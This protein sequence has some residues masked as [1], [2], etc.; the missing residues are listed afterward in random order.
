MTDYQFKT[1]GPVSVD[2]RIA[3]G[4]IEI[5][6][7]ADGEVAVELGGGG[8]SD[9]SVAQQGSTIS[10]VSNR[11]NVFI[12]R[13]VYATIT[14][15]SGSEVR[16]KVASAD[17]YCD[18][19]VSHIS[20]NSASGD[21]RFGETVEVD[22]KTASGDLRG[23]SVHERLSFVSASGDLHLGDIHGRAD[24]STASGDMHVDTVAAETNVSTMSGDIHIN[25]F[26][27]QQLSAKSMS[28]NVRLGIPEGTR[29]DL[30]ANS[31]SGKIKLPDRKPANP[32]QTPARTSRIAVKLVSGD[33]TIRR[34]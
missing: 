13:N 2:I 34:A 27:G 18:T 4:K 26:T 1:D 24:V 25:E 5:K 32:S 9:V 22:A 20:F 30:D 33:L 19:E 6:G 23:S 16:A 29:V 21:L 8:A 10:V 7:G 15:P 28:G 12:D 3:A 31:F 17:L 11:K 14:V